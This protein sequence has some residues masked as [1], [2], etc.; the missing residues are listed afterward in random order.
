LRQGVFGLAALAEL[1]PTLGGLAQ[2]QVG[3]RTKV[4]IGYQEHEVF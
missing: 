3:V 4:G 1:V 2:Q